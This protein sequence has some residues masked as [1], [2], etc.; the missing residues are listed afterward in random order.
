[1]NKLCHESNSECRSIH[2]D[3][4]DLLHRDGCISHFK[5]LIGSTNPSSKEYLDNTLIGAAITE[6]MTEDSDT[7][8]MLKVESNDLISA[9]SK[10]LES[11][12]DE[13]M[14]SAA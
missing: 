4:G 2:G 1:M 11:V 8:D 13:V 12:L 3:L 9:F 14:A 5:M 10:E 6:A 7:D